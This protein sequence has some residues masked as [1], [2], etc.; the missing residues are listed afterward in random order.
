MV[1]HLLCA[2]ILFF[3]F[4]LSF[5]PCN[6]L[7]FYKKSVRRKKKSGFQKQDGNDTEKSWL[8]DVKNGSVQFNGVVNLSSCQLNAG[9]GVFVFS[10][11]FDILIFITKNNQ[12]IKQQTKKYERGIIWDVF[13]IFSKI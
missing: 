13:F 12:I 10:S 3:L 9:V 1:S 6:L 2:L 11:K 7:F 4:T 5:P 8:V